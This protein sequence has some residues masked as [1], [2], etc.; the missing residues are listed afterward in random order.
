MR[1][2]LEG[3]RILATDEDK[4][5]FL[6][7]CGLTDVGLLYGPYLVRQVMIFAYS[8]NLLRDGVFGPPTPSLSLRVLAN[9]GINL[10]SA[11]DFVARVRL[12]DL[13]VICGVSTVD[14]FQADTF[15]TLLDV[16]EALGGTLL[17]PYLP[18][19][20]R[21]YC[22]TDPDIWPRVAAH[23]TEVFCE[24]GELSTVGRLIDERVF[25]YSADRYIL[26]DMCVRCVFCHECGETAEGCSCFTDS[27]DLLCREDPERPYH[28]EAGYCP[29]PAAK[30]SYQSFPL[31][32]FGA[33]GDRDL[34]RFFGM[35]VEVSS[36]QK[37]DLI[38]RFGQKWNA[39]IGRDGS[40]PWDQYS[41]ELRCPPAKGGVA[42]DMI[43][44]LAD[45]LCKAR[46]QVT[47]QCGL[48]IHV[49]VRRA[50]VSAIRRVCRAWLKI[51]R[52][53]FDE[54]APN[55]DEN[56]YCRQWGD[57]DYP[58]FGFLQIADG[59]LRGIP[60][61]TGDRY[62]S[63]NLRSYAEHKTMEF[64]LFSWDCFGE[65]KTFY[66]RDRADVESF[67]L[68]RARIATRLV[69]Y[70]IRHPNEPVT[71]PQLTSEV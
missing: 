20:I 37:P 32:F 3:G 71:L 49:D 31:T 6:L 68:T 54:Y 35:E 18:M 52:E 43:S 14:T 42:R 26:R 63:L 60:D 10:A 56:E 5:E 13:E 57:F 19:L 23:F 50:Y 2:F 25:E 51:E 27:N 47:T 48:H 53:V 62:R 64:R 8:K 9:H 41:F 33:R 46:A 21:R 28:E 59:A 36:V 34:P 61:I 29:Q 45:T 66:D 65:S 55:R 44:D 15:Q 69:D 39:S 24:D 67:L 1:I 7:E 4:R 38:S 30:I 22:A 11:S 16:S 58:D 70:S 17:D 40:L 12:A